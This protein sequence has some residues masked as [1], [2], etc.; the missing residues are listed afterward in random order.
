MTGEIKRLE[1]IVYKGVTIGFSDFR[2]LQGQALIDAVNVN[3]EQLLEKCKGGKRNL[4]LL[5]DLT[6]VSLTGDVYK[7]TREVSEILAPHLVAR[8]MLGV[9][10]PRKFVIN[11]L[12][13]LTEYPIRMCQTKQEALEWLVERAMTTR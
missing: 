5:T 10:G 6:G 2:E 4:L 13:A 7:R 12:N 9:T 11:A 3:L 1:W 8:A